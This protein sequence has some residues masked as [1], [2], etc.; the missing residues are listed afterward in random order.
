LSAN[1][2]C[3]RTGSDRGDADVH[4]AGFAIAPSASLVHWAAGV[5]Y[6]Q[7]DTCSRE[8]AP[9]LDVGSRELAQCRHLAPGAGHT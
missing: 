2:D 9:D 4:S 7:Q 5:R 3:L 8:P 1:V 6:Q